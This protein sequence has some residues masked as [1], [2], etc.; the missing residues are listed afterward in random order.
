MAGSILYITTL[1]LALEGS[2]RGAV[3]D[4]SRLTSDGA[5]PN[6]LPQQVA[7]FR[8]VLERPLSFHPQPPPHG[9]TR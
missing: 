4:T 2:Q 3:T 9:R 8:P 5:S 1:D 6:I 7:A